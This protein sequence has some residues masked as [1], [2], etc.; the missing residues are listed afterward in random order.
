MS[1]IGKTLAHYE[2]TSKLGEG[3]MGV[4]YLAH[5]TSLDR[6][7][8][9]KF[10]PESL[11]QDE[12]AR[13]RFVREA[14]SAAALDHPFICA[15]HEVGEAEGKSYIVMEYLEGQ[16]LRDGLAH[17]AIPLKDAM[18]WA[19]EIAEALA[20]AHEK[21]IVHRDLKPANIMLLQTGH[22]KVMDFGLAKQVSLLP[23]SGSQEQ[24][25]TGALTREGTTVGTVPY[26]S[27]EQVQGKTVDYRSDLFSFGIVIYEMLTGINPF[28]RDSGFDTADAILRETPPPASKYRGEVPQPLLAI[29]SKLLAK[30]PEDRYQNAREA[31]ADLHRADDEIFGQQVVITP[32]G[33]AGLRKALRKPAYWIPLVLVLAAGAYFSFQGV[34]IYQKGKWAREVAP[35]EIELLIEQG[36]SM[37]AARLLKQ[38]ERHAPESG[39]LNRLRT[40]LICA[41]LSIQTTPSG[42]DIYVRDYA[43]T[44]DNNLSYWELLGSSP[45]AA[46]QFPTGFHRFRVVKEGFEPVEFGA[47]FFRAIQVKLHS[48]DAI[49][50][51]MVWVSGMSKG[52]GTPP[53]PA[54]VEE[55]W[56]DRYE[57]TNRQ[58]KKFVDAGGYQKREYW[59]HPFI[60]DG[61][62]ISWEEAMLAFRGP[63]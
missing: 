37:A 40:A 12:T 22:A 29:V 33:F 45:F 4:V 36:R 60:K 44:E 57:V 3:G 16:T 6:K 11:N 21:G 31:A 50:E 46:Q 34:K 32:A 58:F 42:A 10:L 27:P 28:K 56:I 41:S 30:K 18:Q 5:D 17:G 13:K 24:T 23:Q 19:V 9:I 49:P 25:L 52:S 1:M 14:R 63:T 39:D 55:Y 53:A 51:G 59:K 47:S 15:I 35:K 43:D 38:A 7:V 20:V 26:M 48:H 2:I 54:D 61:R 62:Q 8:A